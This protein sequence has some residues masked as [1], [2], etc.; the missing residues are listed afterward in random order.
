MFLKNQKCTDTLYEVWFNVE[1]ACSIH[2][3]LGKPMNTKLIRNTRPL[4][5]IPSGNIDI[6]DSSCG[7]RYVDYRERA[8]KSAE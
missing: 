3:I 1:F 2:F 8:A 7:G 4:L 6:L 5:K